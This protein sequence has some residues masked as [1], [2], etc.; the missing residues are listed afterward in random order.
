MNKTVAEALIIE[1]EEIA[2][3]VYRMILEAPE[4]AP[5]AKPGQFVNLYPAGKDILLPRPVSICRVNG[6]TLTLVYGV[7]GKGT[8]EF[9]SR[10]R[11]GV[12]C[13]SSPMG[14]GY[15]LDVF[16]GLDKPSALLCGG[17]LGVPPLVE[18]AARLK[19]RGV[20]V[21]AAVGFREEPFLKESLLEAGVRLFVATDTGTEGF[22]GTA[23]DLIKKEGL[24]A[25]R[26]FAC[27]PRPMLEAFTRHCL[28]TEEDP[29]LSMEERMGCGYGACVGCAVRTRS[30]MRKVCRDGPV[31]RGSGIVWESGAI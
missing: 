13:L 26:Y 1:N 29:Q 21:T 30:G 14:N 8:E 23:V 6:R 24:R 11:G 17:G 15:D 2:G 18:L 19:E 12:I 7:V 27:G 4:A 31:F 5:A 22:H 9:S 20:E 16:S 28:E 3:R 25:D 10:K